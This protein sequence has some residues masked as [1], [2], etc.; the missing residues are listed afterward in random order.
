M[1]KTRLTKVTYTA[2]TTMQYPVEVT[3]LAANQPREVMICVEGMC[4][5]K[6][7]VI[8]RSDEI[9]RTGVKPELRDK[10]LFHDLLNSLCDSKHIQTTWFA[11]FHASPQV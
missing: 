7:I 6:R 2:T 3:K 4:E 1:G 5:R 10:K 11:K 8:A 9:T